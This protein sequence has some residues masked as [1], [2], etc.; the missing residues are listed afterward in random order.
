[1]VVE[2]LSNQKIKLKCPHCNKAELI[3][4]EDRNGMYAS[5]FVP[6]PYDCPNCGREWE[7]DKEGNW[8]SHACTDREVWSP[9]GK[10]L[11]WS[12]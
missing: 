10:K 8:H 5:G 1:M 9:D 3:K 6:Q 7:Q 12:Q 4:R 11:L 2:Y